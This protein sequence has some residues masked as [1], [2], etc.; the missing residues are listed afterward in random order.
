L[1]RD[2]TAVTS[3]S[4]TLTALSGLGAA[5]AATAV[6]AA[7]PATMAKHAGCIDRSM[8]MDPAAIGVAT[9]VWAAAIRSEL[10]RAERGALRGRSIYFSGFFAKNGYRDA[11][12]LVPPIVVA[13]FPPRPSNPYDTPSIDT[14]KRTVARKESQIGARIK[15]LE[16][17]EPA[18]EI[19]TD[20]LGCLLRAQD[21]GATSVFLATD[22]KPYG[23]QQRGRLNLRGVAIDLL[24]FCGDNEA[25]TCRNLRDRWVK[26][27]Q[28]AGA[29]VAT[30]DPAAVA[31]VSAGTIAAGSSMKPTS[32]SE[33]EV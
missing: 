27:L 3:V 23:P 13:P 28:N 15:A 29:S 1:A 24:F 4:R 10:R 25:L 17:F 21:L 8:S 7:T 19:G 12:S 16:R 22:L 2:R 30:I 32:G 6:L 31:A 14:W 18:R 9:R 11:F 33:K 20:L 5:F 26:R